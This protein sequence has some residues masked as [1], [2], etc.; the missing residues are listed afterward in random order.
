MLIILG[1]VFASI[2]F[3]TCADKKSSANETLS[4]VYASDVSVVYDGRPH[5]ITIMNVLENDSVLYS[6]DGVNYSV[7]R[8]T[9]ILP[10]QYTVYFKVNRSG[11][12]EIA[13]SATVTISPCILTDISAQNVS[14]NYDGRPHTITIIGALPTDTVTYSTD[15]FTY[16][17]EQ[18]S[19]TAVG[20]YVIYYSVERNYGY[21]KSS[22]VLTIKPTVYGKYFNR[23]FGIL[24]LSTDNTTVDANG[25]SGFIDDEPFSI[26]DSVL[27][28]RDMDFIELADTDLVYKLI[29]A[30]GVIYF[31]AN[32]FGKLDISFTDSSANIKLG[33]DTLL[34]VPDYNYCES[35]TVTDYIDLRFE[36][37]FAHTSDVT[38]ITVVLSKRE[39]N[40][41]AFDRKYV[42]YDGE[43]HGFDLPS[44][45][46][47]IS[48]QKEFNEVGT[49]TVSVLI[50]SDEYLPCVTECTMVILADISGT[51]ASTT[52]VMEIANG[53]VKLDGTECGELSIADDKWS[54][55]D[56]PI[57]TTN[58][59]ITYDGETYIATNDSMLIIKVNEQT[60]AAV[61]LPQDIDQII[62]IDDGTT[63]RFVADEELISI[64]HDGN[65]V[66]IYINGNA[67]TPFENDGTEIYIIGSAD[68]NAHI[69]IIDVKTK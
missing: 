42:T 46:T 50:V 44:S 1:A 36:Q 11:Y 66:T 47:I 20:E 32:P 5:S 10:D 57:T 21:Y 37:A 18:P 4:G 33:D 63:L 38:D 68:L 22:C 7:V 64:P 56:K 52:H 51:Y 26:A 40:P 60:S 12:K 9:F 31:C 13:S 69:T 39:Q 27:S 14:A 30:E 49:H 55:N 67:L 43:A 3:C 16:T 23:D 41:I 2:A 24:E 54:L 19:F 61:K 35:G 8:P 29:A 45:A 65:V 15:G 28:Y 34:S 62:V 6:T 48:E 58:D 53:K 59:G 17:A 25:F